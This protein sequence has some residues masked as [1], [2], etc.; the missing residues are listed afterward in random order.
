MAKK[1]F[2]PKILRLESS[3]HKLT[4]AAGLGT[5]VEA[6]DQSILKK[7]FIECLP[8]RTSNRSLGS[9]RFGLIQLASFIRG[10]DCLIDLE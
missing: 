7:P 10:H 9:Y 2:I 3:K 5:L 1:D 4:S 8:E 6:F